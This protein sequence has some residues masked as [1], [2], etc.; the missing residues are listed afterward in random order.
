M[1]A[2][3]TVFTYE[4]AHAVPVVDALG[5]SIPPLRQ[6][7][8]RFAMAAAVVAGAGMWFLC[9]ERSGRRYGLEPDLCRQPIR[10]VDHILA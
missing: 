10:C 7:V 1:V 4:R 2:M 9:C 3:R 6:A 8:T 5:E